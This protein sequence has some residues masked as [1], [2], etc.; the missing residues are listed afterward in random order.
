MRKVIKNKNK[1]APAEKS[2]AIGDPFR[3]STPYGSPNDIRKQ[4]QL[5]NI[6]ARF[7]IPFFEFA[8]SITFY[9]FLKQVVPI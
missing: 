5:P 4:K 6:T 3:T 7:V 9:F 1:A 2:A 8:S